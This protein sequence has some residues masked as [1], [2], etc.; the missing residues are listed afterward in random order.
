MWRMQQDKESGQVDDRSN[1]LCVDSLHGFGFL[2][3]E[4]KN[5]SFHSLAKPR[6]ST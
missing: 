4:M 5:Q 2:S 6:K 3:V 1:Y